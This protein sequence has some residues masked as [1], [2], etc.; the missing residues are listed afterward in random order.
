M[1]K[2]CELQTTSDTDLWDIRSALRGIG[3]DRLFG[4]AI[5]FILY[6]GERVYF[7]HLLCLVKNIYQFAGVIV[8]LGTYCLN[9][10][11]YRLTHTY[12]IFHIY[13]FS[14]VGHITFL[15]SK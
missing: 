13:Y 9:L 15:R 12:V 8:K 2:V 5:C 3:L 1:D 10:A 6:C 7:G 11:Y 14:G 4:T